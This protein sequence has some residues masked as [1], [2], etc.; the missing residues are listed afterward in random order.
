MRVLLV[1]VLLMTAVAAA[2]KEVHTGTRGPVHRWYLHYEMSYTGGKH[3]Q[4]V[5]RAFGS[6][7]DCLQFVG[8]GSWAK[9]EHCDASL[10]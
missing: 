10:F 5:Q 6:L 7:E 4:T 1:L 8:Q 3:W 9:A 2:P